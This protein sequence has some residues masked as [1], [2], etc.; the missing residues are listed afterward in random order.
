MLKYW[1]TWLG[2]IT[3]IAAVAVGLLV[4]SD[5]QESWQLAA[6]Y[7]ARASYPFFLITFVAS[8]VLRLHC[9]PLRSR[10]VG[11]YDPARDGIN[12]DE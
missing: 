11:L 1:P 7:T 10:R 5:L 4:G 12:L 8:S 6:R 9:R 3:G 2:L